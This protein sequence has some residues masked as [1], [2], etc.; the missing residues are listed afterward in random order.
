MD[1]LLNGGKDERK[2]WA[3]STGRCRSEQI[4]SVDV[5]DAAPTKIN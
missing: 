4:D 2:E 5:A 3:D 1:K